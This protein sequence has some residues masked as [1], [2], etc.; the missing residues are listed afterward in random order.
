MGSS[1]P[2]VFGGG[3]SRDQINKNREFHA[4]HSNPFKVEADMRK[5]EDMQYTPYFIGSS[6]PSSSQ[7]NPSVVKPLS[8]AEFSA[9]ISG[10]NTGFRGLGG[11]GGAVAGNPYS[12]PASQNWSGFNAPM[13]NY[14]TTYKKPKLVKGGFF[15]PAIASSVARISGQ[16][17]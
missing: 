3:L 5:S 6:T 4:L 13:T 10:N 11:F 15:A 9:S 17:I 2:T 1:R 16:V 7:F 12:P 8:S 14:N